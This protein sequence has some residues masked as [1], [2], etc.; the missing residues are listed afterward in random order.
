MPKHHTPKN[1]SGGITRRRLMANA[2]AGTA[3]GTLAFSPL[4]AAQGPSAPQRVKGPAV[5]LDMD[6][7]ELD[8]S[9]DNDGF[10]TNHA[11][12]NERRS[13]NNEIALQHIDPPEIVSYGPAEIEKLEIYRTAAPNA[14]VTLFLHGGGWRGGRAAQVA[15]MAECFID[16]GAH[17]VPVDFS[18][19]LQ[20]EGSLYPLV[21]QARRATAWV[22]RNAASFGADLNKVYL[23][24]HSAGGHM[25]GCV[26]TNDWEA[27]DLPQDILK[28]ALL[29]SGMF[30]LRPVRLSS[31]SGYVS[32]TDE[33]EED[34]SPQ[35]H[36]DKIHTP[37]VITYGLLETPDFQRQSRDFYEAVRAAGKP[38]KLVA[39]TAYNH[40]ETQETLGNPYG[41]MGRAALE[42]MGLGR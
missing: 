21:D 32:I 8:A 31:R 15:Y 18:S 26:V 1:Q 17:F 24:G 22:Y 6:Q 14:P 12:V 42:M 20:T 30:D 37:L 29:G 36:I 10:V 27:E 38:A 3:A 2:A 7:A 39:G 28:G 23:I 33:M 41:F 35:R 9:Y 5:W 4:A 16:A 34:L 19:V 25:G 11:Q 13:A 40:Y